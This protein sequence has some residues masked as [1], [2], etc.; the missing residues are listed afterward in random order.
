TG[1]IVFELF[2]NGGSEP[3]FTEAVDVNGNGPYTT[4]KGFMLPTSGPVTGTYQWGAVYS[5]GKNNNGVSDSNP[6]KEQGKVSPQ[7]ADLA[8]T[9]TV[10]HPVVAV[11]RPVVFTIRVVNHGPGTATGVVLR[12][13]LPPGL[14]FV[15]A[16]ATQGVY[17]PATQT[18]LVGTLASGAEA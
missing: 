1:D 8:V 15:S 9:K 7:Q 14:I 10:N 2:Y 18:W 12:D 11:G 4:P 13:I 6:A 3:V 16:V 17:D 5:G